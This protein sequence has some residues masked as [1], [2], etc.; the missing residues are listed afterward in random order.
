M[1]TLSDDLH[2]FTKLEYEGRLSM[3]TEEQIR[4]HGVHRYMISFDSGEISPADGVGYAFSSQL[5]CKKNIQKVVDITVDVDRCLIYFGVWAPPPPPQSHNNNRPVAVKLTPDYIINNYHLLACA[6]VEFGD[7]AA[8]CR[9]AHNKDK[10]NDLIILLHKY[11]TT[12]AAVV[13]VDYHGC[14]LMGDI[15]TLPIPTIAVMYGH[16]TAAGLLL[17]MCCD[18][19]IVQRNNKSLY[20]VPAVSLGLHYT[21]GMIELIKSKVPCNTARDML[22]Y[23]TRYNAQQALQAGI[24]DYLISN[25]DHHQPLPAAINLITENIIVRPFNKE[26]M[27]KVKKGMYDTVI[28]NLIQ[29][30]DDDADAMGIN[31][32]LSSPRS[33]LYVWGD[34][35]GS[36]SFG[37]DAVSI[38]QIGDKVYKL[39]EK[40]L[41]NPELSHNQFLAELLIHRS[42]LKHRWRTADLYTADLIFVPYYGRLTKGKGLE[43]YR[44]QMAEASLNLIRESIKANGAAKILMVHSSTRDWPTIFTKQMYEYLISDKVIVAA[45]EGSKGDQRPTAFTFNKTKD[46]SIPYV[47]H[48]KH[49]INAFR[50]FNNTNSSSSSSSSS[51]D[52]R[53]HDDSIKKDIFIEMTCSSTHRYRKYFAKVLREAPE[54]KNKNLHIFVNDKNNVNSSSSSSSSSTSKDDRSSND[55]TLMMVSSSMNRMARAVFCPVPRGITS[56]SRRLYEAIINIC[57]PIILSNNFR[58]PFTTYYHHNIDIA[59]HLGVIDSSKFI[60]KWNESEIKELPKYLVHNMTDDIIKYMQHE[61]MRV[62]S[63]YVYSQEPYWQL[64]PD[65]TDTILQL[66]YNKYNNITR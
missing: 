50:L 49:V 42:L 7:V 45:L 9:Y 22:C 15:I 20:F 51:T 63:R 10:A 8:T 11:T 1:G 32:L 34:D 13:V 12:T 46:I 21:P 24:L 65:A 48:Y 64:H 4:R 31:R 43:S 61:L 17:A 14:R 55:D 52:T 23:S 16:A 56:T 36:S 33:S 5:P 39:R 25:T 18:Y 28:K 60:L 53:I 57:I 54:L 26:S 58:I 2:T 30:H 41:D 35:D 44:R 6:T 47:I 38:R 37:R 19:R 59:H 40:E 27:G 62:R 3:V 29:H 66:I